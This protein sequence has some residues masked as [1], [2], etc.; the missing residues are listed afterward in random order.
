MAVPFICDKKSEFEVI[1]CYT[2]FSI[3]VTELATKQERAVLIFLTLKATSFVSKCCFQVCDMVLYTGL[4]YSLLIIG[5]IEKNPGPPKKKNKRKNTT[6][7]CTSC[8]RFIASN[9]TFCNNCKIK[10][11]PESSVF[12]VGHP[13]VIQTSISLHESTREDKSLLRS[14]VRTGENADCVANSILFQEQQVQHLSTL[15]QSPLNLVHPACTFFQ[16]SATTIM[17]PYGHL[18]H[19]LPNYLDP[20]HVPNH[21]YP[22]ARN[23]NCLFGSFAAIVTGSAT[24]TLQRSF[25]DAICSYMPLMPFQTFHFEMYGPVG[26]ATAID[27]ISRENMRSDGT[28]GGDLEIITFCNLFA[29]NVVVYVAQSSRWFL[30]SPL[31]PVSAEHHV[32]L[33]HN[34]MHWEPITT[35]RSE[36]EED[37]IH[38]TT[39]EIRPTSNN[40]PLKGQFSII[41]TTLD[42]DAPSCAKRVKTSENFALPPFSI[43]T[44]EN[45]PKVDGEQQ[46]S[47][48]DIDFANIDFHSQNPFKIGPRCDGCFRFSTCFYSFDV[49]QRNRQI[50]VKRKYLSKLNRDVVTLCPQCLFYSS[51]SPVSWSCAWPCVLNVLMKHTALTSILPIQLLLSWKPSV[52]DE[53]KSRSCLSTIFVLVDITRQLKH[54]QSLLDMYTSAAYVSALS[55]Y[56]MPTIRCFCGSSVFLNE[57]GT[58][59]FNH[60]LNYIFEDFKY[61]QSNYTM[62]ANCVRQDFLQKCDESLPFI[63]RPS[64]LISENGLQIATCAN[65]DGGTKLRMIHLHRHPSCASLCHPMENRFA[66]I[67]PSLRAASTL[68]VGQFS[69]TWTIAK[70]IGGAQGVGSLILH[71]KRNLNVKSPFLLPEKENLFYRHRQDMKDHFDN[72]MK[73]EKVSLDMLLNLPL[74]STPSLFDYNTYIKGASF[75]PL[76]IINAIKSMQD[77]DNTVSLSVSQPFMQDMSTYGPRP[78]MPTSKL[79]NQSYTLA[80]LHVMF[81]NC[82]YLNSL[83]FLR[84]NA[85]LLFIADYVMNS[86]IE[87]RSKIVHLAAFAHPDEEPTSSI[88]K[89]LIKYANA[90]DASN[91][92]DL[93]DNSK[94]LKVWRGN[95][96][97]KDVKLQILSLWGKCFMM[98]EKKPSGTPYNIRIRYDEQRRWWYLNLLKATCASK[99]K[100]NDSRVRF[101]LVSPLPAPPASVKS[102]VSG[103]NEIRCPIH[104]LLLCV[105]FPAS[106]YFCAAANH[107]PNKSKWRCPTDDCGIALCKK[108]VRAADTPGFT[109]NFESKKKIGLLHAANVESTWPHESSDYSD[110]EEFFHPPI[111]MTDIC[112]AQSMD[113]DAAV[114]AMPIELDNSNEEMKIIPVQ[115]LLNN[116]MTVLDRPKEPP[117]SSARFRRALQCFASANTS[118]AISLLQLEALLFPSRFFYQLNDGTFPGALPF[119]LYCNQNKAKQFGFDDLLQHFTTRITDVTL[120]T[121]SS[122][123]Y[124]QFA[125]DT[126][127]NLSLGRM[128]SSNFFKKGLQTLE[129]RNE[130][131]RLF[132]SEMLYDKKDGEIRLRELV[133]AVSSDPVDCFLTISCNQIDNPGTRA[134]M[135]SIVSNYRSNSDEI[136]NAAIN[137][138]MTTIVRAWSNSVMLLI[139]LLKNT[140]ENIVGVVK[141]IWARAEFQTTKG[142]LPHYH[143]LIWCEKGSFSVDN[144]I[145]CAK[146]TI[147]YKLNQI[148]TSNLKLISNYEDLSSTYEL[149]VLLHTHECEK[150]SYRC[151]KR[152]DA[153]GRKICRTP[154]FPQSHSNWKM[155]LTRF[156]PETALQILQ[157][158]GLAQNVDG[159]PDWLEPC[160]E[161]KSEKHMY[162]ATKGEHLVA[163][164]AHL[165]L[166]T[167]SSTNLLATDPQM[168]CSYLTYYSSKVE[169][170]A[171]AKISAGKDG[172]SFRLR[173][174]GIVNRHLST[175]RHYL[176]VDKKRERNVEKIDCCMLSVTEGAHWLLRRPLVITNMVFIHIP[177]VPSCER[178][179]ALKTFFMKLVQVN[180]LRC[181]SSVIEPWRK[182]S[183]S[184]NVTLS[185]VCGGLEKPD[186]ITLFSLRPPELLCV[187][188]IKIYFQCFVIEKNQFQLQQ[189]QSSFKTNRKAPWIDCLSNWI[190]VRFLAI[191]L[192]QNWLVHQP[193][194]ESVTYTLQ[195]LNICLASTE[196]DNY[197]DWWLSALHEKLLPEIVFKTVSPRRTISFLVSFV[198]RF[199]N[200]ETELDLFSSFRLKDSFVYAQLI[201]DKA[202][203]SRVDVI[204]L[205][206]IYTKQELKFLPGGSLTFSAKLV[207]ADA[208]F[209]Q[210]LNVEQND[211]F[212]ECPLV[213]LDHLSDEMDKNVTEYFDTTQCSLFQQVKNLNISNI[214]SF[215]RRPSTTDEWVPNIVYPDTQCED[216]KQEQ[217]R[218]IKRVLGNLQRRVC[219]YSFNLFAR[220]E[221]ILGPPGSGKSHVCK[222][223]L[224]YALMN[225]ITS[226][227]T[228]LAARRANQLGGEHIHRLFGIPVKNISAS[229]IADEALIKLTNDP[230]RQHLLTQ[231]QFLVLEEISVVNAELCCAMDLVLQKLKD[232]FS[233]F[234]GV[235][236]LAN[237]DCMQLPNVSGRD[238]FMSTSLLYGFNFNFLTH[239]VRM[240]DPN[241]QRLLKLMEQRPIPDED[242]D[243]IIHLFSSHCVFV[244]S[245]EHVDPHVMR[246]FGKKSAEREA[247]CMHFTSIAASGK[248]H[249]FIECKDE[250][251]L[252]GSHH[253]REASSDV[254]KFLDRNV[255]LPAR[256]LLYP[257]AVVQFCCNMEQAHQ[258]SLAVVDYEESTLVTVVVFLAPSPSDVTAS[259]IDNSQFRTWQ[260][261]SVRK[262]TGFNHSYKGNTVRRVQIPFSNYVAANCHRLLGEEFPAVAT[263]VSA[264]ESKYTLWLPSQIFVIGSRIPALNRLT[265]VGDKD[266]TLKAIGT[267]LKTT[268]LHEQ[269]VYQFFKKMRDANLTQSPV[270]IPSSPFM[271]CNFS[272]PA[273]SGG[274]VVALVS[275]KDISLSTILIRETKLGLTT[276]LRN[277]N[278][279]KVEDTDLYPMQ[280]W[281]VGAYIWNFE[282]TEQR[283]AVLKLVKNDR[284]DNPDDSIVSF[285]R[286]LRLLIENLTANF[287]YCFPGLVKKDKTN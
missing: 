223:V 157:E 95:R 194:S 131:I 191:P 251:R 56:N 132:R 5:N 214:E 25:R 261:L 2:A 244:Y 213:L 119:F 76:T 264:T 68:K 39:V 235:F 80:L 192:L 242:I 222:I 120:S 200:Y 41:N 71:Q 27:Y 114:P 224:M 47:N 133:A 72:V 70:S 94:I 74:S 112:P 138:I 8:V 81:S 87:I 60:I 147:Y 88:V 172:K 184:Q 198:L 204:H 272:V 177:N 59:G 215:P 43:N 37:L 187:S 124:I 168:S 21:T 176:E 270:E 19:Q 232:N 34:Q 266:T 231:L 100:F 141:K 159:D 58:V 259:A 164:S 212:L 181:A 286:R 257:S 207:S 237:G 98:Q 175:V 195:V 249:L 151:L 209:S 140:K 117:H 202:Q 55:K 12:E 118:C 127:I 158:M 44:S 116:F 79:A 84:G 149:C 256:L 18:L 167:R 219:G 46:S 143:I 51:S 145:Q 62:F 208:A 274:F 196:L 218:I 161:M 75:V 233:P 111:P 174:D 49:E 89:L 253:W 7:K 265:F 63:N 260:R 240:I 221:I 227:V 125:V 156:Y 262:I 275:M 182:L 203:Y 17:L 226:M 42:R 92:V 115:A 24:S 163:T 93:F 14:S 278:S 148:F 54:F 263:S 281:S 36:T 102:P 280:P 276:Y 225:G 73:K 61:L 109:F 9:D 22:V 20:S 252:A 250:M 285:C 183:D 3:Q 45:L 30:Y 103:L 50:I 150:S 255:R 86:K 154:P 107:C 108:H 64:I 110:S 283:L 144:S 90:H 31:P 146:K 152:K 216:S 32:L 142:N 139:E 185:D 267:V 33:L 193:Q 254:S 197:A 1:Y 229:E 165:F 69:H 234:G 180:L 228:S 220:N 217:Q 28:Y 284:R 166:L 97:D 171:D 40:V 243:E 160:G 105:D 239:L 6:K 189:L 135:Q 211:G 170:H 210:L 57:C 38:N 77:S 245:W 83:L 279:T 91:N 201:E 206:S 53:L 137:S 99:N 169:E 155:P 67:V 26:C 129:A 173:S 101:I 134:I 186:K 128:H 136:K 126:L 277:L 162:T 113:T 15:I 66:P 269:R 106:G 271:R 85:F 230:K 29:V 11:E 52:V 268:N 35:I 190:R 248:P 104:C 199:G 273:T 4:N 246:I 247:M 78:E 238:V 258:G 236:V 287:H 13:S 65:H 82:Q 122:I 96:C 178:Y 205:L 241:G 48:F 16:S 153:E 130:K 282:C 188:S 10:L 23:G 179:V 123:E 121:S